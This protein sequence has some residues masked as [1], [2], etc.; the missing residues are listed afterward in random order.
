MK[1]LLFNIDHFYSMDFFNFQKY[2]KLDKEETFFPQSS[3]QVIYIFF[4]SCIKNW[5]WLSLYVP[6]FVVVAGA[7]NKFADG[8][9]AMA[10]GGTIA[11][12]LG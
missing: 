4:N 5:E 10:A 11:G 1:T 12:L 2:Y 9:R 3:G 8:V 7:L 6:V